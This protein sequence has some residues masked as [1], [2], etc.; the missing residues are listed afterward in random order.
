MMPQPPTTNSNPPKWV[1]NLLRFFLG[2]RDRDTVTGDLLEEY[3][4]V[5]LPT[6]GRL[7]AQVWYL[8][9]ALSL[10]ESVTSGLVL[11]VVFGAWNLVFTFLAPLAEDTVLA[12]S[13]FYGPMFVMWGAVGF[14]ARRRTGKFV[15]AIKAG[16]IVGAVTIAVFCF[17]NLL[18]VNLFLETISQRSDWRNLL[19]NFESSD[20]DSLRAYVNY[21]FAAQF[22]QKLVAGILIGALSGMIGGVVA[23]FSR[24]RGPILRSQPRQML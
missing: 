3:R 6:R 8:R 15:D 16:M 1:E 23:R 12:L 18:R 2:P 4:E 11:G 10:I 5:V 14:A 24:P 21:H 9:Q 19:V 17:A 20:F 22:V 13:T 7:R